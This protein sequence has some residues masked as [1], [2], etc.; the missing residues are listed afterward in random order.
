MLDLL[1]SMHL[2]NLTVPIRFSIGRSAVSLRTHCIET[3]S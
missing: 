1:G 3:V 2:T